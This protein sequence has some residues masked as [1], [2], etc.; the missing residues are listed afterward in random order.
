[1][2][3]DRTPFLHNERGLEIKQWLID[4]P[5]VEDYVILDDEIYKSYDEKQLQKLVKTNG[6]GISFGEGLTEKEIVEI[7]SRFGRTRSK[8]VEERE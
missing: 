7:V 6:D 3:L 2:Y 4:N 1:M 5:G 8:E